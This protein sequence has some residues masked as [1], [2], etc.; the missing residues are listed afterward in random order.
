[1]ADIDIGA[2]AISR[3]TYCSGASTHVNKEN[4]AN[5]RGTLISVEIWARQ[6]LYNCIVG[7]F[8]TTNGNTLKCRDSVAIGDIA[9]G[10]KQTIPLDPGLSVEAGDYIGIYFTTGRLERDTTG[11]AGRWYVSYESIDPG[12]EADYSFLAGDAISLYGEGVLPS[13]WTGKISG[14]TNPAKIMGVDVANIASVKGVS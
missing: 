13:P 1:M 6:I 4:P 3:A 2:D 5:A 7:T 9:A 8:Y 14:V 11:Y 10:S 12:D